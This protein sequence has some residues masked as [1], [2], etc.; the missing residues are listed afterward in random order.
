[1]DARLRNNVHV[2][3]AGPATLMLAHGFGCGPNMW[4][5]L[6]VPTFE[7]QFRIVPFDLVGSGL[8][9]LSAHDPVRYGSL[10]GY[11]EDV[12]EIAQQFATGLVAFVGHSVSAMIGML[13]GFVL[14]G[15]RLQRMSW[16]VRHRAI[17]DDGY[18]SG[19][20]RADIDSLL[21]TM[22]SNYLGWSSSM[23]ADHHGCTRATRAGGRADQQLL[24]H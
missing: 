7:P 16:S 17:S 19:F 6:L 12:V 5:L 20:T 10:Q 21:E 18:E 9:A 24:P 13:A 8:S 3:G 11:A 1:M 22:E 2:R 15:T 4:R 14:P 23:A